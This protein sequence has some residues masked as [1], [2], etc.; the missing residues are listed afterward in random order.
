M[1]YYEVAISGKQRGPTSIFTYSYADLLDIGRVVYVTLRGKKASGFIVKISSKPSYKTLSIASTSS[2]TIPTASVNTYS[3][4]SGAYPLSSAYIASLFMPGTVAGKTDELAT[5]G[6]IDIP[7]LNTH[8]TEA[9][10]KILL[11]EKSCLLYGDTGTGKTRLYIHLIN[12]EIKKG[13]NVLLLAPE[14]GLASFLYDEI[15]K[16]FPMSILYHS[17]LSPKKRR[18]AWV[19]AEKSGGGLVAIGPRSALGLPLQNIGII[20]LDEAHDQSYR[21]D[22]LPFVHSRVFAALLAKN[23]DAYCV[24]GSA[25]PLVADYYQAKL[26]GMPIVRLTELATSSDKTYGVHVLDYKDD[27]QKVSSGSLLRSSR[28][29]LEQTFKSGKQA[30]IL[31][32]RRGTARYVSCTSC[33]HEERCELCDHLLIYHHDLHQLRC[34]FCMAK[35]P[36]PTSCSSCGQDTMTMRSEGTKAIA[37]ELEGIFPNISVM[38]F[39]TDNSRADQLSEHIAVVKSGEVDCIVGTQMIAKGLDLPNLQTLVVIGGGSFSSGF[40]SEEREFQLLYQVIGRAIRGHQD[41][42]IFIQTSSPESSLLGHTVARDYDSFYAEELSLRQKFDYPPFCHMMIVHYS[43]KSSASAQKSGQDLVNKIL[44]MGQKISI[45]PPTPNTTERIGP[46]Y[47][48]HILL[49]S[50]KRSRL[51]DIAEN[52]GTN[53]VCELDPSELP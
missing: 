39:D 22:S 4:L 35:Y 37:S 45:H 2:H 34:H 23:N 46:D 8:Q 43:R 32:N 13:K 33:G 15:S 1:F 49:K 26:T 20:V 6:V 48:W 30:L 14:I 29:A 9:L 27:K 21:Q 40:A 47:N 52:L 28:Q 42:Q 25:T 3:D 31:S 53:V 16:Y 41:T 7:P 5:K 11:A 12:G 10:N 17:G 18:S 51:Y 44:D 19:A 50:K 38:R 24:Y 36:V